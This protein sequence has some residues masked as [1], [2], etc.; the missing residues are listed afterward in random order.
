MDRL[1]DINIKLFEKLFSSAVVKHGMWQ[2]LSEPLRRNVFNCCKITMYIG[3]MYYYFSDVENDVQTGRYI[4]GR[5]GFPNN[6]GIVE[7][8]AAIMEGVPGRFGAVAALRG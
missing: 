3:T 5:G 4:V 1:C 8:D 7:C 2:S 6:K